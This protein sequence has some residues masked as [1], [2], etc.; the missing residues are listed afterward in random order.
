MHVDGIEWN[1]M[2]GAPLRGVCLATPVMCLG[3]VWE[4]SKTS[5]KHLAGVAKPENHTNGIRQTPSGF[6]RG[7]RFLKTGREFRR[8]PKKGCN[9]S[10]GVR[11]FER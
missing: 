1:H 8:I 6:E 11:V 5:P 2:G 4:A 7:L 9:S 10:F 3:G